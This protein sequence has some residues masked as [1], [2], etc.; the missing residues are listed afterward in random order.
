[1]CD[2][3]LCFAF[4]TDGTFSYSFL[5]FSLICLL[6]QFCVCGSRF[7]RPWALWHYSLVVTFLLLPFFLIE[8]LWKCPGVQ[9]INV[10]RPLI[11]LLNI[12]GPV[13][14]L[15]CITPGLLVDLNHS[16]TI[17]RSP[18]YIQA[19]SRSQSYCNKLQDNLDTAAKLEMA[20]GWLLIPT[21]ALFILSCRKKTQLKWNVCPS[22]A[23]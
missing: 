4:K 2:K 12:L 19:N 21:N 5:S 17:C 22:F 11:L 13:L 16:K 15:V 3:K 9:S 10:L 6:R 7:S 14:F 18:S 20:G 1:M 23:K 8:C